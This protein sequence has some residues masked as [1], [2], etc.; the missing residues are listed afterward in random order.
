MRRTELETNPARRSLRTDLGYLCL[1]PVTEAFSRVVTTLGIAG[2]AFVAGQR[3]GPDLLRGFG[4]VVEQS[5]WLIV[6]EMLLLG[7]L[8]YYWTH[9]LAHAVPWLWR[10]HAV[11]HSTRHLRWT[12]ALRAHPAEAYVHLF[13]VVPLFLLGFPVDALAMLLPLFTL[14]ALA[15]HANAD[16]ALR[17][18]SYLVNSPAYHR[19]HHARVTEGGGT[20]FAGLFPLYDAVFG[21]YHLP[22]HAPR[23]IGIDE[24]GMPDTFFAQLAYP[25]RCRPQAR[26]AHLDPAR[27]PIR[28][29]A[30]RWSAAAIVL[31]C[32]LLACAEPSGSATEAGALDAALPAPEGPGGPGALAHAGMDARV[33]VSSL[34]HPGP[35]R[36]CR[37]DLNL[38][39]GDLDAGATPARDPVQPGEVC[40]RFVEILCAAEARCCD[41]PGRDRA[42]CAAMQRDVCT[43]GWLLD[44]ISLDPLSGF[45]AARAA[46]AL[47][48]VECLAAKCDPGVSAYTL[49]S[50]GLRGAFRGSRPAG[51]DC[52]PAVP[53]Y[54][55]WGSAA[56]ALASCRAIETTACLPTEDF[57]LIG[58]TSWTCAPRGAVGAPCLTHLNCKDGLTCSNGPGAWV[59]SLGT[60]AE[61]R[62]PGLLCDVNG[63]CASL[64]CVG[65]ICA[66]CVGGICAG[67]E[68][69][70]AAY[71]FAYQW[72]EDGRAR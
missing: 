49:S 48:E 65:G 24:P 52:S 36:A 17:P 68:D 27:L 42:A 61:G 46:E 13:Q 53:P 33:D 54:S 7:D 2:C 15:I 3:P 64:F 40:E 59:G 9:R 22:E 38:D 34:E 10:F 60:C 58:S 69:V 57:G 70:Q 8:L 6:V 51:A 44:A 43:N 11:H 62:P 63:Q 14:Y 71:C 4:P 31:A 47:A 18:L 1:S 16:V 35:I 25:F 55:D 32:F 56:I 5:R 19:W 37:D 45:D 12:S 29:A 20:N 28:L 41:D 21:T 67:A 26:R 30:S 23:E 66:G 50:A 72:Q 39:A